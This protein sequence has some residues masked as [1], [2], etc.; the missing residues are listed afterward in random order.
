MHICRQSERAKTKM[1]RAITAPNSLSGSHVCLISFIFHTLVMQP[2]SLLTLLQLIKDVSGQV[3]T[4]TLFFP[5]SKLT[6]SCPP[7]QWNFWATCAV[8]LIATWTVGR[9]NA[10]QDCCHA[11]LSKTYMMSLTYNLV[12][13]TLM[14][15]LIPF[16]N[17]SAGKWENPMLL[18]KIK[19]HSL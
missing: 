15:F 12:F 9:R 4:L 16:P 7:P 17:V 5:F 3:L 14:V 6:L 10:T 2:K 13:S 11:I 18:Q 8:Y 1:S 19:Q